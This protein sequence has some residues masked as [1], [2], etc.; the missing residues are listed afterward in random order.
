MFH[1]IYDVFKEHRFD[2]AFDQI[3]SKKLMTGKLVGVAIDFPILQKLVKFYDEK[4]DSQ[5][6]EKLILQID[7]NKY[8]EFCDEDAFT[9][10]KNYLEKI[11]KRYF[12]ISALL[13]LQNCDVN[14]SPE[15]GCQR[16]LDVIFGSLT[17]KEEL[18]G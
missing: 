13:Q 1:E 15:T 16:I 2:K 14:S 9:K 8:R 17:S 4:K 10:V 7:I 5:N 3:L 12:L 18:N 6:L 11:C